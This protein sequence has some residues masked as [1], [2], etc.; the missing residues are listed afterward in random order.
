M[1]LSN[2]IAIITGAARG[3]GKSIALKFAL[4]G[5]IVVNIDILNDKMQETLTSIKN[6][7]P[8][9]IAI[10]CNI[11]NRLEV[12]KMITQVMRKWDRVDI[13]VNNAGIIRD[14][15]FEKMTDKMW[16]E[17]MN[18]NLKGSFIVTQEII[19]FMKNRAKIASIQANSYGKIINI[20]SNSADG[21]F[22][23]ANYAASKAG[24]VGLTK[25]LAIEYAKY[26]IQVNA[27]KPGFINTPMTRKMPESIL[28]AKIE[29]IPL[30]RI[31]E[32][33]DIANAAFFLASS[34]SDFIT[35][36]IIRVDGGERI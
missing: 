18:V 11:T 13:L 15:T 20:S 35:G 16:D 25:S 10:P 33:E 29:T 3:I 28:K 12:K 24:L 17:V 22:G 27:I 14:K 34:T 7:S 21:N 8:E 31:G 32:P 9:S 30:K 2:K 23:Q 26:R 19:R 36:A 5:A 6:I 1:T 4:E